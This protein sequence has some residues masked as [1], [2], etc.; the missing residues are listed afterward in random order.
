MRADG[1]IDYRAHADLAEAI[2]REAPDGI[3]IFFDN[4]GGAQLDAAILN[5]R[6]GGRIVISGQVSE[7][8]ATSPRGIRWV[9]PFISKRLK[10]A[11]LVV[12]DYRKRFPE[13]QARLAA[14]IGEGTL[15][16]R[17]EIIEGFDRL[18]TA[19]IGLFN[20][21]NFGRRLVKM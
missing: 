8:N 18:P 19:F 2:R 16:Y 3:D 6:P 17:E 9:T 10:M 21:E 7:Y 13:A 11:G 12:Y 14:W 15:T 20:H 5:M 1:C 4:V